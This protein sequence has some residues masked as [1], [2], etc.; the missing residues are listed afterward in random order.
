MLTRNCQIF[1]RLACLVPKHY[2]GQYP[3]DFVFRAIQNENIWYYI[4]QLFIQ[5]TCVHPPI[6][7]ATIVTSLRGKVSEYSYKSNQTNREYR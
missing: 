3:M 5:Y 1:P 2:Y 4:N 6:V 7:Q